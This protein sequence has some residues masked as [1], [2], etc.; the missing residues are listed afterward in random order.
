LS[1]TAQNA[2]PLGWTAFGGADVADIAHAPGYPVQVTKLKPGR[3]TASTGLDAFVGMFSY[4]RK[5]GCALQ[6]VPR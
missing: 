5:Y 6:H 2:E 4:A 3:E 1:Q